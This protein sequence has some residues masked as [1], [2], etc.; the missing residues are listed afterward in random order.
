MY[1][2][3][4]LI[5]GNSTKIPARIV[6]ITKSMATISLISLITII[7]DVIFLLSNNNTKRYD[8]FVHILLYFNTGWNPIIFCIFNAD[9]RNFIVSLLKKCLCCCL[10]INKHKN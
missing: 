6:I 10:Y 4:F 5:T 8:L 1:I 9:F 7:L 3:K 2:Y